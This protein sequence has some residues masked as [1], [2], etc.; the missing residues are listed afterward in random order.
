ML[1]KREPLATVS[2]GIQHGSDASSAEATDFWLCLILKILLNRSLVVLLK[3]MVEIIIC[4]KSKFGCTIEG[5]GF[6]L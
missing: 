4:A 3:D 2:H 1:G 5:Y 6:K